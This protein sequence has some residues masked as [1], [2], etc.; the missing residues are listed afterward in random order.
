[1]P[2]WDEIINRVQS[3]SD[4]GKELNSIRSEF[5]ERINLLTGRNVITYYSCWLKTPGAPNSSINDQ[6]MNAFM[7]A[8]HGLDRSKGLDLILHTPGGDLAATESL[9]NY[10]HTMFNNDIRAII[11]QISMSAGTIMALSCKE[12]IMGKQS[13]L[14]PIDPQL[15]GIACQS[16][17]EEFEKAINDVTNN[18]NSAPLWQVI[19]GRLNP[20]F[21]T[22]C[23]KAIEWSE[24]LMNNYIH[25]VYGE[26][27]DLEPLKTLFLNNKKS[28]S[29]SRHISRDSCKSVKLRIV[30]LEDK[31]DL[32]EAVLS[33]HH[34]Y[35]IMFDKFSIS[36]IVE[37]QQGK[38]FL[39]QYSP[40][41][42]Q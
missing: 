25:K 1:M 12:V 8:V 7:N 40:D 26:T 31:Q 5:L 27:F 32:Q 29:H 9:V 42:V 41:K 11:P 16:V 23:N 39:Q 4:Q 10:L 33:L 19:I 6:D 24:N 14:G 37:N 18:P 17:I 36:K 34:A 15:G 21:I 38:C 35:M 28:Y 13:S 3:V 30:D 20:T 22:S 2:S